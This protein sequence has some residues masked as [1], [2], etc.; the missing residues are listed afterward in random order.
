M[1][2]GSLCLVLALLWGTLRPFELCNHLVEE[3]RAGCFTLIVLLMPFD[4]YCSVSLPHGALGWSAVCD[5]GIS[6]SYSLTFYCAGRISME[7][8]PLCVL[9]D[10]RQ[11][12]LNYEHLCYDD[13]FYLC[14]Q[15]RP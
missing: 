14:K 2:F 10:H 13:L 11:K 3:E 4:C 6:W 12:Y 7:F 9:R 1:F 15:C 8:Y 5:C